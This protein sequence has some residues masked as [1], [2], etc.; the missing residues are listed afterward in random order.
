VSALSGGLRACTPVIARLR[1]AKSVDVRMHERRAPQGGVAA[2][3]SRD[4]R[5]D[6]FSIPRRRSV[7]TARGSARNRVSTRLK[8]I[9]SG[10]WER[11][12][13][14]DWM[15]VQLSPIVAAWERARHS[16]G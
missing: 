5:S 1:F 15:D 10:C 2:S 3:V 12:G 16:S 8:R 4:T 6:S 14:M 13:T 11:E 9:P 7:S